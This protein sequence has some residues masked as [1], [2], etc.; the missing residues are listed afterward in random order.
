MKQYAR[1]VPKIAAL[2]K[3]PENIP[4]CKVYSTLKAWWHFLGHIFLKGHFASCTP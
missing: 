2:K 1:G 4:S 3:L